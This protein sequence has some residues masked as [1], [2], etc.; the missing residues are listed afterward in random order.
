MTG[1]DRRSFLL[2]FGVASAGALGVTSIQDATANEENEYPYWTK[3]WTVTKFE[4]NPNKY[5]DLQVNLGLRND[6]DKRR[7]WTGVIQ[8]FNDTDYYQNAYAPAVV[9]DPG[10]EI[11]VGPWIKA[12][13]GTYT[14]Q[15][16]GTDH[17][18]EGVEVKEY[19]M[20]CEFNE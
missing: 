6:S 7:T 9:A 4:A 8:Y 3:Y 18:L 10:E 20:G 5:C 16:K 2:G 1:I 13:P 14:I 19:D 15:I 17:V 12:I 11:V